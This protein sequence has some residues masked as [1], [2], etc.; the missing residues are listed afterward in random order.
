MPLCDL[1]SFSLPDFIE[2][3]HRRIVNAPLNKHGGALLIV[4]L[5]TV[6]H[7]LQKDLKPMLGYIGK[8][9]WNVGSM[10]RLN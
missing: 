1:E 2:N 4:I 5:V 8:K 9:T 7:L 6:R 3:P 10:I